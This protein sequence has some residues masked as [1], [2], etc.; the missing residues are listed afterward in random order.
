MIYFILSILCFLFDVIAF[1]I[2]VSLINNEISSFS[3]YTYLSG[4]GTVIETRY[5]YSITAEAYGAPIVLILESLF[6]TLSLWY[7]IWAVSYLIKLP[8]NI[9]GMVVLSLIGFPQKL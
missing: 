4:T 1:F 3:D 7:V 6:L 9:S 5:D 8:S 2:G